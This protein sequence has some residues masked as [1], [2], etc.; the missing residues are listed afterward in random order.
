MRRGGG[1]G[2]RIELAHNLEVLQRSRCPL[3]LIVWALGGICCSAWAASVCRAAAATGH[4]WGYAV[5]SQSPGVVHWWGCWHP[6]WGAV[7]SISISALVTL[8]VPIGRRATWSGKRLCAALWSKDTVWSNVLNTGSRNSR[9]QTPGIL[10]QTSCDHIAAVNWAW[11][12]WNLQKW[13]WFA[14]E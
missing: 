5:C 14:S 8:P 2:Q 6:S 13:S 12:D 1:R 9:F 10:A 4:A 11:L 3:Y 7:R